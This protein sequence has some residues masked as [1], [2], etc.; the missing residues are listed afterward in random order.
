MTKFIEMKKL[1]IVTTKQFYQLI[2]ALTKLMLSDSQN[3]MLFLQCTCSS[4]LYT[5]VFLF[6]H[7]TPSSCTNM[8]I[9]YYMYMYVHQQT[10]A[11]SRGLLS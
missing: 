1:K 8:Y 11:V 2:F 4:F 5:Y 3:E 10:H 7:I 9:M 6:F